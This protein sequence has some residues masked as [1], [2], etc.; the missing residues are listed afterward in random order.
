MA[1][2]KVTS[3]KNP[4]EQGGV[5]RERKKGGGEE[6]VKKRG[7]DHFTGG[8]TS[9]T[10]MDRAKKVPTGGALREKKNN[11]QGKI[12]LKKD[13]TDRGKGMKGGRD[14]SRGHRE[15]GKGLTRRKG[16]NDLRKKEQAPGKSNVE[17]AKK[18]EK[19]E[20]QSAK[21]K[22]LIQ[23]RDGDVRKKKSGKG[24]HT[25]GL[26]TR[27]TFSKGGIRSEKKVARDRGYELLN[28]SGPSPSLRRGEKVSGKP[29]EKYK[30]KGG[31]N[32]LRK[33][34]GSRPL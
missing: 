32:E 5:K 17:E 34:E 21:F 31:R 16:K 23:R 22:S 27:R 26:R 28:N 14:Q 9:S 20:A 13:G 25:F 11:V 24:T 10:Y 2:T 30:E 1:S 8:R 19:T 4:P 7:G 12:R 6:P 15:K 29:R 33:K 3:I 18:S